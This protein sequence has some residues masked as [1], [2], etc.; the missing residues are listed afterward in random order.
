MTQKSETKLRAWMTRTGTIGSTIA[1]KLGVSNAAV[2]K[3]VNG[4]SR[5]TYDHALALEK[6][7][8][9]TVRELMN[10]PSK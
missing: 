6:L 5:P 1:R 4:E 3:W 7:T 10:A 8:G 2:Y 9:L